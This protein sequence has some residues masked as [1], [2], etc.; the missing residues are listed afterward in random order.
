MFSNDFKMCRFPDIDFYREVDVQEQLTNILFL[1]STMHPSIGYRQGM[2][3]ALCPLM[4][5]QLPVGMHELLAPLYYSVRYD[6]INEGELE[7][8]QYKGLLE[9]CSAEFTAADSWALFELVM[10]GV[11]K[12]YEWRESTEAPVPFTNHVGQN[13]M[14]PFIAPIVQ[15]CNHIQSNMLRA[16]DPFLC[17]SMQKAGIEP[18]I[19]GMCVDPPTMCMMADPF[20]GRRWLRLLFTR[21]FSMPDA[22]TLWDGLF[23][24]DP[25]LELAQ[26]ICVAMLIRIRN[27]CAL[28]NEVW[29]PSLR[30]IMQ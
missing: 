5:S 21:E 12:W 24:C 25:T 18:Q 1:Y 13:G 23:A 11:Y 7:D 10:N 19:Y 14:Q 30:V 2:L 17:Q 4:S 27:E 3:M 9:V 28:D 15:A 20:T 6:A 8:A 16:C 29:T 26:W 22:L